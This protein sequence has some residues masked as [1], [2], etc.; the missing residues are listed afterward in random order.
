M[1]RPNSSGSVPSLGISPDN[2]RAALELS[3]SA[4]GGV[5][6]LKGWRISGGRSQ[7]ISSG[8]VGIWLSMSYRRNSEKL[9]EWP[10]IS[11]PKDNVILDPGNS[12]NLRRNDERFIH[13]RALPMGGRQCTGRRRIL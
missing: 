5:C 2:I 12:Y 11:I 1:R 6:S 13:H 4:A 8:D 10:Q 7:T 9:D 3:K